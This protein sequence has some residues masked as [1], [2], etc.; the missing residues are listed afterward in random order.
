MF[1]I[2]PNANRGKYANNKTDTIVHSML[3]L[4]SCLLLFVTALILLGLSVAQPN[5]RYTWLAAIGGA[6]LAL[7]SVFIWLAQMPVD[8][9][10]PAWQPLALFQNPILFRADAVSW[11]YAISVAGITL[12]IL[13]TAVARP[14]ST[15]S[16]AWAGVLALGGLGILAV[17]ANNPFT[18]LLIWSALDLSELITQLRSV[19]G[20]K[21][22]EKVV[23]SFST[24]ALG[25]FLLLWANIVSIAQGSS[26]D[27]QSIAPSSG[28]Y[29]VAAAG[30]RLGV[31]PLHLPYSS[32]SVLRRGFGTSLRL[33]AAASSLVLLAHVPA[34][35]L[36]SGATPFLL[37]LAII[38]AVYG[39]WM[40]L[41]A[42][43]ELT[44]RP[45]WII[46]MAALSIV[47]T[48]NGNPLGAIAWG[49]ALILVGG[50]LFL[51]SVQHT[52]LNR[53]L[54]FGAWSLSSL[55][56]SLTASAWLGTLN[57]FIP[58]AIA[59]QALLIAGLI[60]HT[61]RPGERSSLDSQENWTNRVYP[62]GIILPIALQFIL[63][64][65]G[66]DGARQIGA[67]LLAVIVSLLTLGLV[68]ATP[69]FRILNP[70]RA[71]WVNPASSNATNMYSSFWSVYRIF[72]RISLAIT[73]AL[74]GNG[75]VMWTLLFLVLF[76]SLL[77]QG[78]P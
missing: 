33:I 18:L 72:E 41:R 69:R 50:A 42:P 44:G 29:F 62:A 28:L 60:R 7:A 43:D 11:P 16:Y 34:G 31:F 6:M 71:H 32:E 17:T 58:F 2:V 9:V 23:I 76:I 68:W 54:L 14:N 73:T 27:F 51:S 55:P 75:G 8:L 21:N 52:W 46:G 77:S 3:I 78:L 39:G 36:S 25:T 74:E 56:F 37:A 65:I 45:Y 48:L 57:F 40:W 13:L 1:T 66:W 59:A 5:A 26:F 47:A 19:D 24:R 15:S 53:V 10:F 67:W 61:L 22:N 4:I 35:S 70:I 49:C 20:P 30:L 63:G 64:F 38:A 12:T